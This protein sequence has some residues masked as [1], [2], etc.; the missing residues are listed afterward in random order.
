M[1]AE[2]EKERKRKKRE[3]K[4][5]RKRKKEKEKEIES[6]KKRREPFLQLKLSSS[7]DSEIQRKLRKLLLK[8]GKVERDKYKRNP[9]YLF[10]E[11]RKKMR[12]G[13]KNFPFSEENRT[14]I[15][16][17]PVLFLLAYF[18]DKGCYLQKHACTISFIKF[19][20]PQLQCDRVFLLILSLFVSFFFQMQVTF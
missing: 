11:D 5:K 13:A 17:V 7:G 2:K 10:A 20:Q 1:R 19:Q 14:P 4:E 9:K 6:K 15:R 12:K 3:E 18:D 16:F 8:L